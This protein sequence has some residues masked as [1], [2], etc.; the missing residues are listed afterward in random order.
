[1]SEIFVLVGQ[2][3]FK[4]VSFI[5]RFDTFDDVKEF[6]IEHYLSITDWCKEDAL[7]SEIEWAMDKMGDDTWELLWHSF[8]YTIQRIEVV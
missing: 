1:M 8:W 3:K 2:N 7:R 4:E 5:K 6:I